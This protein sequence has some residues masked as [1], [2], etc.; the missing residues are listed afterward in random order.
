[1]Q[2][3]ETDTGSPSPWWG[4]EEQTESTNVP[5]VIGTAVSHNSR[6]PASEDSPVSCV[7]AGGNGNMS[8]T[9]AS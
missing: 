4:K 5:L 7:Q 1:M 2:H 8:S 6:I 3:P 9:L